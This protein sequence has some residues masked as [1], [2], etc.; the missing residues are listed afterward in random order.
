[1]LKRLNMFLYLAGVLR[2]IFKNIS[3]SVGGS[4]EIE[5]DV[6]FTARKCFGLV[7]VEESKSTQLLERN[8]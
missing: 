8:A 7:V 3:K 6:V 5:L 4:F 2:D 1:M